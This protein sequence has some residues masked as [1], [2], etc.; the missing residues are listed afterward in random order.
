[1]RGGE[2][3]LMS[4][5]ENGYDL[6][7][8]VDAQRGTYELALAELRAGR[9]RSH[10]MWFIFP[11]ISGLGFSPMAQLYAIR[12]VEE[13]RAYLQHLVLGARLIE[14]TRA[15]NGHSATS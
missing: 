10:W 14:C 7:R 15:V 11:Q 1:M 2:G 8:F 9:K 13:A 3:D 12:A 5:S 4:S 6:Q